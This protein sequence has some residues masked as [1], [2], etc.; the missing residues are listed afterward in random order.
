M[1]YLDASIMLLYNIIQF[2]DAP[3]VISKVL[4]GE[5]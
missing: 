2:V 4:D 1:S 3:C 5:D